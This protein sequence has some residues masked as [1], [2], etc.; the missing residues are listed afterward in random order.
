MS[1][2]FNNLQGAIGNS[3]E[4]VLLD[5]ARRVSAPLATRM[6]DQI[7]LN[8]ETSEPF[9]LFDSGCGAGVVASEV[10]RLIKPEV[11]QKSSILCGDYSEQV[12]GLVQKRI[13]Q[14]GW[15]N[16]QAKKVDAQ[17]NAPHGFV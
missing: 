16:T 15:V 3:W 14:E 4:D 17:V 13:D 8:T 7:G 10:H 11:L 12:I 2:F 1:K 9:K 5:N 6:L